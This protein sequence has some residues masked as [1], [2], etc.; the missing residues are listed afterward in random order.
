MERLKQRSDGQ[1]YV[2]V[3]TVLY[4]RKATDRGMQ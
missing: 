2:S 1:F 3:S 4:A